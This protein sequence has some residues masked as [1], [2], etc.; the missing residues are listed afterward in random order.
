MPYNATY[1]GWWAFDTLPKLN[2]ENS[3]E[4]YQYILD[5]GKKLGLPAV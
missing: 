4:L 5:I 1:D 3:P 2:Y